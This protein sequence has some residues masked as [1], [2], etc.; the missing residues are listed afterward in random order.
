MNRTRPKRPEPNRSPSPN[1]KQISQTTPRQYDYSDSYKD[2]NNN[3][4][5][6]NRFFAYPDVNN[7]NNNNNKKDIYYY[8]YY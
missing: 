4:N 3:N 6:K 8:Y 1:H 5:N 7:N 2:V